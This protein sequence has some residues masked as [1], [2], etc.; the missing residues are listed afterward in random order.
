MKKT[1]LSLIASL[2]I[3]F[4]ALSILGSKSDYIAERSLWK[5]NKEFTKVTKD[6]KT[7][8]KLKFEEILTKYEKFI[9][10]YPNSKL[11][12]MAHIYIG[13]T[14]VF[15]KE[16][17]KA[18]D[19]FENTL[20]AYQD[21]SNFG[22]QILAEIGRTYSIEN[23]LDNV[24]KNYD[25][26]LELY[27]LTEL[28]L[29]TPLLIANY[30]AQNEKP[31]EAVKAFKDAIIYYKKLISENPN[32]IVEYKTLSFIAASYMA[33]KKWDEAINIYAEIL[34]KFPNPQILAPKNLM[35]LT[36][37]INTISVVQLKDFDKPIK[38]YEEFITKYEGHPANEP[39]KKII[40]NLKELKEKPVN[41]NNPALVK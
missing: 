10:K 30:Y 1:I 15:M 19:K 14:Y 31:L 33:Q 8:P 39:L 27:P 17:D 28:G 5:I 26:I 41:A 18:R 38:I 35:Y 16:Y 3:V 21:K 12:P 23:D 34:M 7:T 20:K 29:K 25:R 2:I 36:Q 4:L 6:P 13:R 22:V 11:T 37:S 40:K 9:K 24:I 32:T